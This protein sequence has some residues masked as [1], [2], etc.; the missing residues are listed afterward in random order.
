MLT[1]YEAILVDGEEIDC[2]IFG[3][4]NPAVTWYDDDAICEPHFEDMLE[5]LEQQR[6]VDRWRDEG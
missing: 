1:Y 4:I 3:C 6:M 2:S 5:A